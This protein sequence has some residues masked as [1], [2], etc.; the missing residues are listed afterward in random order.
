M[1][2]GLL[3]S[4]SVHAE[5]DRE[6][7][8]SCHSVEVSLDALEEGGHG[9]VSCLACHSTS[10][11][12][13]ARTGVARIFG[14]EVTADHPTLANRTS[15]AACHAGEEASAETRIEGIAAHEAHL[16][17]L[18]PEVA[19]M[20]CTSCHVVEE[21]AFEP[22]TSGCTAARCHSDLSVRLGQ[23]A[24]ENLDCADCHALPA[25]V[26][27]GDSTI[28]VPGSGQCLQCHRMQERIQAPE[29]TGEP[30]GNA[31]SWCHKPHEQRLVSE[32]AS[33]CTEAGCHGRPD[34]LVSAH[35]G[36]APGVLEGC[37]GCHAPH[38]A[39]VEQQD[40]VACH[41]A[42]GGLLPGVTGPPP[43]G[44]P[45][46]STF[47]GSDGAPI[48]ETVGTN[49]RV[50]EAPVPAAPLARFVRETVATRVTALRH[51]RA[52]APTAA[53]VGPAEAWTRLPALLHAAPDTTIDAR[54]THDEHTT[55]DC[56]S[57]HTA[58]GTEHGELVVRT[59]GDCRQC[60]HLAEDAPTCTTC[61]EGAE[62]GGS[63]IVR[64]LRLD[65][66]VLDRL[67][68]RDVPFSHQTHA[69]EDCATCHLPS[70]T[71]TADAEDCQGCHVEHHEAAL[72][73]NTCH[74]AAPI[75]EHPV[76]QVHLGCSGSGCHTDAPAPIETRLR[77]RATCLSCHAEQAEGHYEPTTGCAECHLL[78]P[79]RSSAPPA[80]L[81]GAY[82]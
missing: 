6:Y 25:E 38:R 71:R 55:V 48:T 58:E 20:P 47:R 34:T 46:S 8:A 72:E 27:R 4:R 33:T 22:E 18:D 41:D 17:S 67:A 45:G 54:F 76:A 11:R 79:P 21:H 42:T 12:E 80:G 61:H 1:G 30:H 69:T 16:F 64:T 59:A 52:G 44:T 75:E 24:H 60:H 82:P 35:R 10:F 23:M 63:G 53:T 9:D 70:P 15:C 50:R 3:S 81:E 62:P 31:C 5:G 73:C 74:V 14:A 51:R 68:Y 2:A 49:A 43:P 66:S 78:P 57:C 28:L 40:C 19:E 32:A 29:V 39:H 56:V 36:L 65:L 7:C 37:V 13:Q 26:Q 77:D